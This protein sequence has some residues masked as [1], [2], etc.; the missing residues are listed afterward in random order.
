[1]P[2]VGKKIVSVTNPTFTFSREVKERT[3]QGLL[4]VYTGD[5]VSKELQQMSDGEGLE[6]LA[7]ELISTFPSR[8]G[9]IVSLTASAGLPFQSFSS[10]IPTALRNFTGSSAP[11][12]TNAWS[13]GI[14]V[15]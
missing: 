5:K 2:I 6:I 8:K 12:R 10:S 1:M 3:G 14:V 9:K 4:R 13:Y 11:T 7:D 15:V